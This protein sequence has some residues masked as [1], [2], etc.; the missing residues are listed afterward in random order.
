MPGHDGVRSG[1]HM[2]DNDDIPFNRNFALK[3]GV[4]DEVR[5]GVGDDTRGCGPPFI[6][7]A[8]GKAWGSAYYHCC[9]R[10]KRS[11]AIDFETPRKVRGSSG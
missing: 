2:S 5:P 9:N 3:P 6:E 7:N 11:L 10:G 4:V 8:D 1:H